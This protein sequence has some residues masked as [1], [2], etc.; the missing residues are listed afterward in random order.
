MNQASDEI[1]RLELQLDVSNMY[2]TTDV[3]QYLVSCQL[4]STQPKR[5][6]QFKQYNVLTSNLVTQVDGDHFTPVLLSY[7]YLVKQKLVTASLQAL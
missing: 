1:N 3:S 6:L 2:D 4:D 7:L 5:E